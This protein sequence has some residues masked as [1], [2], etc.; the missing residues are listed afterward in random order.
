[1]FPDG[2]SALGHLELFQQKSGTAGRRHP[3]R[4]HAVHR[5]AATPTLELRGFG[6]PRH[7]GRRTGRGLVLDCR[8]RGRRR[9]TGAEWLN[10]GVFELDD[11]RLALGYYRLGG[12]DPTKLEYELRMHPTD[13]RR[14]D[15]KRQGWYRFFETSLLELMPRAGGQPSD[16]LC[17]L[18]GQKYRMV[19]MRRPS[20]RER[21]RVALTRRD[22]LALPVAASTPNPNPPLT[23]THAYLLLG[24]T[25]RGD[26]HAR[27]AVTGKEHTIPFDEIEAN[28]QGVSLPDPS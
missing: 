12:S 16:A 23:P 21:L 18:L 3:I 22:G 25:P 26:V 20:D 9:G 11:G 19:S 8:C 14:A 4:L 1:M 5:S 28:F 7:R 17:A 2:R 15:F 24:L 10:Q 27:D 13:F 6:Q